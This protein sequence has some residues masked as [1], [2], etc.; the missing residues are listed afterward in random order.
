M[1][2]AGCTGCKLGKSDEGGNPRE[3]ETEGR[4][5]RGGGNRIRGDK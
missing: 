4:R 1:K 5:V 2:K 3:D